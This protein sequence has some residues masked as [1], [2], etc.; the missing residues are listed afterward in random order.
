MKTILKLTIAMLA[1]SF[2][3]ACSDSGKVNKSDADTNL[4]LALAKAQEVSALNA[5]EVGL[6]EIRGSYLQSNACSAGTCAASTTTVTVESDLGT[7]KGYI[8][9][10]YGAFSVNSE[11]VEYSNTDKVLYYKTRNSANISAFIWT[12][13]SSNEILVCDVFNGKP[14]LAETKTDLASRKA[15]GTV[16]TTNPKSAG[17]N[18]NNGFYLLTKAF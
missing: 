2:F 16:Y 12:I 4:L 7:T 3:T 1:I 14:T 10:D 9:V 17:C 13:T 15:S 11:I 5:R 18:G 8:Y 6:I